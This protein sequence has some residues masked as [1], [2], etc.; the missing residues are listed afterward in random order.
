[1]LGTVINAAAVIVGSSVGLLVHSRLP[2]RITTIVFQGIG[3]FT[4]FL[5]ITMAMKT[6]NFLVMIFSIVLGSIVG[7]LLDID[8]GM[9]RMSEYLKKKIRLKSERF[10]EGLVTAFLIFCMGSM[11]ILGPI[12]EGL[13]KP[14]N[15]LLAKSVLDAF[16]SMALAASLGVG[17]AFSVIPLVIYQGGI[18]L[19]AGY[20][21]GFFTNTLIGEL[22][23]V[24]GLL[25]IG[26]GINILE[27][28][29]LKILNMLPSLVIV[30]ILAY[31]FLK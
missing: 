7:E 31:V 26:L 5:G 20:V 22:T 13:G 15:I 27:I 16:S 2:P 21:Q 9:T 17:V 29:S 6:N 28:K 25:L 23:A 4:L 10:S 3:L 14:P 30:V 11:S 1:M 24:G 18:T 8:G 12:E 19:F